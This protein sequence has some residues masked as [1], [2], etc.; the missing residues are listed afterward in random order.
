MP[1]MTASA[2]AVLTRRW[3]AP[4]AVAAFVVAGV[5]VHGPD[6]LRVA[7]LVAGLVGAAALTRRLSVGIPAA[8]LAGAAVGVIC[9]GVPSNV[10]WFGLAVLVGW[11]AV[12]APTR[13]WV[14]YWVTA[15]VLLLIE[16]LVS[17][18]D[19]GWGAWLAGTAFAAFGCW[20]GRR[21]RDLAEQ[22]RRAQAELAEQARLEERARIAREV[23]D[24]VAH[25]L[26]VSLLHISGARL[27]VGDATG[28][29]AEADAALGQAERLTRAALGEVRHTV[30]MLR[31]GTAH[32]RSGPEAPLPDAR[33]IG[34]LVDDVR[35]AGVDV[36]LEA[37]LMPDDLPATTGLALYR[38]VQESLTNT[39]RH[40]PGRPVSVR[41]T[42]ADGA[43]T[44]DVLTT[45]TP[46]PAG[47]GGGAGL[48]S[49]RQR[50]ES[51]G[52]TCS[53]GPGEDGWRVRAVLP[54]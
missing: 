52:G 48:S 47:T 12:I 19:G 2:A 38:I 49:M 43:V 27:A 22:L 40:A 33:R 5:A 23:H 9:T 3:A 18:P 41:L 28:D 21:Q 30:G 35:A 14:P 17:K 31:D 45:G 4:V 13:V 25:A 50:A 39:A 11:V 8:V 51:V 42:Q 16:W 6:G 24:V 46:A 1:A 10:G 20:F 54:A 36:R 44:V 32:P 34:E 29:T 53:A 7:G 26:T 15:E 37:D